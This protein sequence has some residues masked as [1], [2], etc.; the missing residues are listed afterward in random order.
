MA[1][2][3]PP[4]VVEEI[5]AFWE[6]RRGAASW[7]WTAPEQWHLTLAFLPRVEEYLLDELIERLAAAA[8]RRGPLRLAISGGGAFPDVARA[9]VLWAGLEEGGDVD[10]LSRLA[11]GARNAAVA[12][13]VEVD[14][15]RFRPHLTLAR[16][17][18][19]EEVTRWLRVADTFTSAPFAVT[20]MVLIASHLGE[21]ARR[22]PRYERL[23]ELPIGSLGT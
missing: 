16:L 6:P 22:R 13:G 14:G 5:D 15:T 10:E 2:V 20:E 3:P 23:A 17:G 21:G 19:P 4:D 18:H 11:T 12:T 8:Q 9:K 1:V 7:R